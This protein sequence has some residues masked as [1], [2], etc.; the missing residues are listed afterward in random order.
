MTLGTGVP[1]RELTTD[2]LIRELI[3]LHESRVD[4][5]RFGSDAAL[6]NSDRRTAELER[7]Y[8][9]RFPE[10]EVDPARLRH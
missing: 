10:R 6:A 8:L 4:T 2:D 9:S 1:P 3:S 7:E 5:L